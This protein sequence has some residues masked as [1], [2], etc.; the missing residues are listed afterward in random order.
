M[1]LDAI[2][3]DLDGTLVDSNGTHVEAWRRACERFGYRVAPDRIFVEIGKGGDNLVP[4][5]LGKQADE[6]DGD[7]LRKAEPEEFGKL[8]KAGGLPVFPG[9]RELLEELRRRKLK[10]VLATSSNKKQLALNEECSGLK[11]KELVDA[12]VN[13]DDIESSK[14][15][16]D[17]VSAAVEK[18]KMTPAQCAMVGDTPHDAEAAKR[19]GV[20]CLGVT[21]GGHSQ[22]ALLSAGARAVFRDPAD[23]LENLDRALEIASPGPA[24]LTQSVLEMLMREALAVAKEGMAAGE[25]PIGAVLA[26]GNGSIIA[27]GYNQLNRSQNEIAHAEIVTF[28]AAAGKVPTDARDLILVSTLEPCVMCLGASMEAAVDTILYALRAPADSGTNRVRP[29]QSPESIMPRI[30]GDI[31][32]SE[33]RQL[34]EQWIKQPGKNPQQREFVLQLLKLTSN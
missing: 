18:L 26:R 10:T 25:V 21:C 14:P 20:V 1:A 28:N 13:A 29:P 3:F 34:F 27:R 31:L 4:D 15:A 32:A 2:I 22:Q 6:K 8:A 11:V 19:A 9:A 16:P 12:I 7:G 5:L 33:S 24:H 17:L 30:V 23:L